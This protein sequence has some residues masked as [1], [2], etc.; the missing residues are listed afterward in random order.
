MTNPLRAY[1]YEP[2]GLRRVAYVTLLLPCSPSLG[3]S[4]HVGFLLLGLKGHWTVSPDL[5]QAGT[6]VLDWS[7]LGMLHGLEPTH[8]IIDHFFSG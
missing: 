6:H 3:L 1:S 4:W 7:S 2:T 5:D 8:F